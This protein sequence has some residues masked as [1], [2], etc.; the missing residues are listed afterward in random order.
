[1]K[2]RILVVDDEKHMR[3]L[4]GEVLEVEGYTPVYAQ[5]SEEALGIFNQQRQNLAAVILDIK[6]GSNESG[7][8]TLLKIRSQD[9]NK[10]VILYTAY[11]SFQHDLKSIAADYYVVKSCDTTE[12]V[13]IVHLAVA[14]NRKHQEENR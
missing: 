5:T 2:E 4:V 9:Q 11:D 3:A 1:M 13:Q 7:L 8:D 10:P 14:K 6:L 12:L